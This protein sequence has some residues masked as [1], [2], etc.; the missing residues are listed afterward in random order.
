MTEVTKPY[1]PSLTAESAAAQR[2]ADSSTYV[3]WITGTDPTG[4]A[5]S[6]AVVQ[7]ALTAASAGDVVVA[8]W[9]T[10]LV[11]DLVVPA[12]VTFDWRRATLKAATITTAVVTLSDRSKVVG[13]TI[14][15]GTTT[16]KIGLD[17]AASTDAEADRVR[18]IGG[19]TGSAFRHNGSTRPTMTRCRSAAQRYSIIAHG[20]GIS[21][22]E[23]IGGSHVGGGDTTAGTGAVYLL[24]CTRLR[25][26]AVHVSGTTGTGWYIGGSTSDSEFV[27]CHS[28]SNGGA[29]DF[30]GFHIA[31]TAANVTFTACQ[32]ISNAENGFF[33]DSTGRGVKLVGCLARGNNVQHRSGGN[34][35]E[36]NSP[37]A[38][39][40]GCTGTGQLGNSSGQGSGAYLGSSVQVTGGRFESNYCDGIRVVASDS[41]VTGASCVNNGSGGGNG[42]RALGAISNISIIGN[43]CVD[44]QGSPTQG[45]GVSIETGVTAYTFVPGVAHGNVT[46]DCN[47]A[48]SSDAPPASLYPLGPNYPHTSALLSGLLAMVG[49]GA[50]QALYFRA[51]SSGRIT[52]IAVQVGVQSGNICVGV[53]ANTGQGRSAAP[54]ARRATS[55]SVACPAPG[56]AEVALGAAVDVRAGDWLAVSADNVT[57]TLAASAT[58]SV[59]TMASGMAHYQGSAFP[60]PAT[61]APDGAVLNSIYLV[62]VA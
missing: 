21:D 37:G 48:A 22:G 7:A 1:A 61:A 33:A 28:V 10:L 31:D 15:L 44:T 23:I 50:N 26:D 53:H 62:G 16:S 51:L 12:D 17:F 36:I 59:S 5:S 29:G 2:A 39:L 55:G 35:F 49:F 18:V 4:V 40:V 11:G 34:G 47:I 56:Y 58:T 43:S 20:G 9:G 54:G 57:V 46:G 19:T 30:R 6:T 13:G 41:S 38:E 3:H 8:P 42:I 52:K 27:N 24:N 25:V 45:Y 60:L 14:D 32:A